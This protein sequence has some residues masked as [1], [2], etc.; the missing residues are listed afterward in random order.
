MRLLSSALVAGLLAAGAANA[1]QIDFTTSVF[2]SSSAPAGT[3]NTVNT[4]IDGVGFD[5]TGFGRGTNSF[6][7]SSS[8]LEFGTGGNGMFALSLVADADILLE[9]LTASDEYAGS[10]NLLTFEVTIDGSSI[11]NVGPNSTSPEFLSFGTPITLSAGSVLRISESSVFLD[12]ADLA[13]LTFSVPITSDVPLPAGLP[14][15]LGAMG[16]LGIAR[17]RTG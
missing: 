14:L 5:I 17:R 15:M 9:G 13:S 1:A 8:G 3:G 16:I 11:A 6:V 4:T 10:F 12:E 2:A 7:Q